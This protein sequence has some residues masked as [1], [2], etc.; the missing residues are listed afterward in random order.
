MSLALSGGNSEIIGVIMRGI[1]EDASPQE[2]RGQPHEPKPVETACVF[3]LLHFSSARC[4][5][6]HSYGTLDCGHVPWNTVPFLLAIVFIGSLRSHTLSKCF[7]LQ[8]LAFG[9]LLAIV[10]FGSLRSH[11]QGTLRVL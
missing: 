2:F 6:T 10:F 5:R 1:L 8:A 9:F 7:R 3:C 11:P 4:A